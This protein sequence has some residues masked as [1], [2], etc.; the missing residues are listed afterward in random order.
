MCNPIPCRT[1]GKTT[2]SGCGQH[3][4]Q[5]RAQVPADQWCPGHSGAAD[6]GATHTDEPRRNPLRRLLGR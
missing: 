3:I 6:T 1:C 5:V 4:D 2:W